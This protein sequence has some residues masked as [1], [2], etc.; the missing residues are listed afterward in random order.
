MTGSLTPR[1][2]AIFIAAITCVAYLNS[3][4]GQFVF[5]DCAEIATNPSLERLV[6]PWNAM[7]RGNKAPAR[8]LP[9]L[10]FAI[11]RAIW[12]IEP[13]GYHLTNLVIHLV[14]ALA[15][16]EFTR[17]TL[18]SPRLRD[19]WGGHAVTLALVIAGFWAI[20]P[21]QTQAVTY[22]YQRIESMLGM[23]FLISLAA[24]ARALAGDHVRVWLA[25]SFTACAAAM[26]C[27]ESAVVLPPLLLAY[28]W[29]F[30]SAATPG[31]WL[32]D[33]R[34]RLGFHGACFLTWIIVAAVMISQATEYPEFGAMR[35]SP[36]TYALTQPGVILH[37]LQLAIFPVGQCFE[38]SGWPA[39]ESFSASQLPAYGSIAA[40]VMLTT[41]GL[42]NRRPWAW[43]GVLFFGALAPTSSVLPVDALANEHR[44][45]LPLAAVVAAI[46]LGTRALADWVVRR[47][48]GSAKAIGRAGLIA[49]TV[50]ALLLVG[51]TRS[52]NRV[53]HSKAAIW[54]DVLEKEPGNY[55]ALWQ[56]ARMMDEHGD[57][58]AAFELADRAIELKPSCDVYGSLAA[59]RLGIG[60][61][62]GAE[63]RCRLG[64]EQQRRV[65]PADDRT[66]LGTIADLATA[67]R[68]Q[69]KTEEAADLCSAS[70]ADMR[71]VLGE[72]DG[73]TVSA[74]QIIAEGLANRGH[75][76]EAEAMAR[77]AL[78][79]ARKAKSATDPIAIN[80]AVALARVLDTAGKTPDAER[81]IRNSLGELAAQGSRRPSDRIVLE[82]MLAEFLEKEGKFD[83]AVAV[84]RHCADE[85]ER[86]YGRESP[87]TAAA[88]TRHALAVAAQATARGDHSRA[89]S[90]YGTIADNFKAALGGDHALT[91]E[92]EEKRQAATERAREFSLRDEGPR[93]LEPSQ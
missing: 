79:R 22:V 63:R 68:L 93:P 35:R 39:V 2:A 32:T 13:F 47:H 55:R 43:L 90:I 66:V 29:L 38:H 52:R 41:F 18:L 59:G 14:A 64:L 7:F 27:K 44:M 25:A 46:V 16:F 20:H 40:M 24:F 9:Y 50:V 77:G 84:R 42:I 76:A 11:D 57:E 61:Y 45:Y 10:T 87:L 17:Q 31:I 12:G 26:A 8:P 62:S 1:R 48:F 28:D 92:M 65:L 60:D 49:A 15:L 53:Y 6:P 5:D 91:V 70:I 75:H 78:E 82:D 71:R 88:L 37:Y 83:E 54:N 56:F 86:L 51:L 74:E 30:S 23:F 34:R 3:F 36:L 81:V 85:T 69:A 33:V 67:L 58:A 73:V 80:A 21:L 19:R 4:A 72:N 89:A